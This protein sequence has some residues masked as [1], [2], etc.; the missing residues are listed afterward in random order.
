MVTNA[1]SVTTSP[2]VARAAPTVDAD[3]VLVRTA[4]ARSVATPT[5]APIASEEHLRRELDREHDAH[6]DERHQN[7]GPRPAPP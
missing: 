3:G 4:E 2:V 5:A 6:G 7:Q 1:G